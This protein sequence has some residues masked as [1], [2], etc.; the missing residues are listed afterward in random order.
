MSVPVEVLDFIDRV[1][2]DR[3]LRPGQTIDTL[4]QKIEDIDDDDEDDEI[5]EEDSEIDDDD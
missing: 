4:I 2:E 3:N 5:E 1:M